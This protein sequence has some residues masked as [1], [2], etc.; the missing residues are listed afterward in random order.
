MLKTVENYKPSPI[1]LPA[2]PNISSKL[3]IIMVLN[4]FVKIIK[5]VFH[6]CVSIQYTTMQGR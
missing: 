1:L 5:L 2:L 4:I 3:H 6:Y